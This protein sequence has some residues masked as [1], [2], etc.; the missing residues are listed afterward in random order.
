D[1]RAQPGRPGCVEGRLPGAAPEVQHPL[2]RADGGGLVEARVGGGDGPGELVGVARPVG[3]LGPVPGLE[4]ASVR[5]VDGQGIPHVHHA[6]PY[7]PIGSTAASDASGRAPRASST[8]S[9][10]SSWPGATPRP[11][12]TPS[13][14]A[15]APAT[16]SRRPGDGP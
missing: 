7:S 12:T 15:G 10:R 9:P 3:A 14:G 1:G 6:L 4:L 2:G 5:L 8:R 16:R 11:P 13:A